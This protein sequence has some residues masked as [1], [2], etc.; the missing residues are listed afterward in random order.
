[1]GE[2]FAT[3]GRT[4][5]FYHGVNGGPEA[6]PTSLGEDSARFDA[7]VPRGYQQTSVLQ[8]VPGMSSNG[9]SDTDF[10]RKIPG[11]PMMPS[12]NGMSPGSYDQSRFM[13]LNGKGGA[14]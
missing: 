13:M 3:P 5:S 4:E 12:A 2:S 14:W 10:Q 1:M 9:M 6:A 8:Q 7:Q 11:G